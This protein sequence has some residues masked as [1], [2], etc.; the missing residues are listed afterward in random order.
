MKG[1]LVFFVCE[2]GRDIFTVRRKNCSSAEKKNSTA[3]QQKQQYGGKK[4]IL[5]GYIS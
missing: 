5:Q 1:N 3:L 4:F 2:C